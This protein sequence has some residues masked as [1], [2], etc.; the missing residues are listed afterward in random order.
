MDTLDD[1]Q[2]GH[3]VTKLTPEMSQIS[4]NSNFEERGV[5]VV[6]PNIEFRHVSFIWDTPT[7]IGGV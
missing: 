6:S 1:I 4:E 7:S 3:L 2:A 5:L